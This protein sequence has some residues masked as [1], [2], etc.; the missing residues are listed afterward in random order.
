[1]KDYKKLVREARNNHGGTFDEMV[2]LMVASMRY[3][4]ANYLIKNQNKVLAGS[5]LGEREKFYQARLDKVSNWLGLEDEKKP[6]VDVSH[7]PKNIHHVP[8]NP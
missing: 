6:S 2:P 8:P 3:D 7:L 4:G 1:M 5:D